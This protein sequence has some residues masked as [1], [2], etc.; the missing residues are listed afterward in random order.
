VCIEFSIIALTYDALI[1][2][3]FEHGVTK[4]GSI[5]Q[6][7]SHASIIPFEKSL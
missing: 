2:V 7:G 3:P 1:A 6:V 4:V 5:S